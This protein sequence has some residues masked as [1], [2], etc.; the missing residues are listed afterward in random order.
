MA[1][2]E[3]NYG[4][5]RE[6]LWQNKRKNKN[7]IRRIMHFIITKDNIIFRYYM[8]DCMNENSVVIKHNKLIEAKYNLNSNE[9]KIILYAASLLDRDKDKFN[10]IQI[11]TREFINLLG[12]TSERYSEV[13]ELV[14]ELRKKEVIIKLD[15]SKEKELITGWL[16]S[17][18]YKGDGIIELEFSKKLVP[19]LIQLQKLFT[20]YELRNVLYLKS[21]YSIRIYELLKQYESIG[22]REFEIE[23]FKKIIGCHENKYT[24]IY[25][26]EKY[27]LKF[28]QEEI[29][30]LTDICF[31]YEKIKIGRKV[32][33]IKFL[34]KSKVNKQETIID[35]FYS[36]KEIE[37]IKLK[38]GL[39]NENF[40]SKQI[41][42]LYEI[43]VSKTDSE[44]IDPFEYI[45]LNYENMIELGTVRS[46]FPW[47]KK[48][49]E[50]DY[51]KAAL[52][53][54]L[55]YSID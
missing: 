20:K 8:E 42:D 54:K 5:R 14:R 53:I 40:N 47:L 36:K 7:L 33:S 51:A 13:R 30:K 43:A 22:K 49:L 23:E 28:S 21:K 16:S 11:H 44:D 24:R 26:F 9:Q 6:K 12:T 35:I 27:V 4:K 10:I 46:K 29:C 37:N 19:Y 17:I 15:N 2:D 48:A 18:E 38:S 32:I 41:V 34:I 55:S 45:R 31:E 52:Q 50:S 25:D 39:D 3:K 1:K